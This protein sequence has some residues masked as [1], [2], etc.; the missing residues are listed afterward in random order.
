[1]RPARWSLRNSGSGC[2]VPDE[3]RVAGAAQSGAVGFGQRPE[4]FEDRRHDAC[5]RG[6]VDVEHRGVDAVLD[7]VDLLADRAGELVPSR[8]AVVTE[9]EAGDLGGDHLRGLNRSGRSTVRPS[10]IGAISSSASYSAVDRMVITRPPGRTT[11]AA[12]ASVA[13]GSGT[14]CSTQ[15]KNAVSTQSSASGSSSTSATATRRPIRAT[16]CRIIGSLRSKPTTSMPWRRSPCAMA[17]VPTPSSTTVGPSDPRRQSVG[18]ARAPAFAA[19]GR[20]VDVG[21]TI[22]RGSRHGATVGHS[23]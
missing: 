10:M 6:V 15:T 4:L 17:P 18:E 2:H 16:A 22:E 3:Q 9:R 14:S 12:S 11:R 8:V 23:D 13:S 21:D 19:T 20:V 1:L 5:P 7:A